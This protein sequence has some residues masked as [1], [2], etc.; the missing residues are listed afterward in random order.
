MDKKQI[1]IL[2]QKIDQAKIVSFDLYDTL[3][4]RKIRRPKDIFDLVEFETGIP[5]FSVSREKIQQK[6]ARYLR[7]KHGYPHPNLHEIY[8]FWS[9]SSTGVR[10]AEKIERR[11]EECLAVPN[12]AMLQILR[13]AKER[14]RR[15]LITSDMYLEGFEIKKILRM[16]AITDWDALYVSS[17]IRKTKYDGTIYDTVLEKEKVSAGEILHI[18][19]DRHADIDM[20]GQKGIC[21]FWYQDKERDLAQ[22][23]YHSSCPRGLLI[24]DKEMAFWYCLGYQVGG[25]LYMGLCQWIKENAAGQK[26]YCLSRDGYNLS[27][28]LPRFGI[29]NAVYIYASRRALLLPHITRIGP[30]E[31]ALL[32]PYSCGQTAGEI[33]SSIG[34]EGI[35][36]Q[37]LKEA[38]FDGYD[39]VIRNKRDIARCKRLYQKYGKQLLESCRK[40]RNSLDRYFASKGMFQKEVCFFDSGWN[41][42]SQYLIQKIYQSLHKKSRLQFYY[43]GIKKNADSKQKLKGCRCK[44]YFDQTM[45]KRTTNKLL[46][47]SAVLELFF[48]EDAPAVKCYGDSIQFEA[49]DKRE[50]IRCINQGIEDYISQNKA[51]CTVLSKEAAERFGTSNL[52]KLVLKP[53]A[54]EAEYIGNME[55]EDDLSKAGRMKKYMARISKEALKANPFLD[56]YWEQG[57]YRHPQNTVYVKAYVWF[58]QRTAGVYKIAKRLYQRKIIR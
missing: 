11:L 21:V 20:A 6:A 23:L 50:Y 13:Y 39:D 31:L 24:S 32:P 3:I 52:V 35:T 56:I 5:C 41:G 48:S 42:T 15:I 22:S 33:L 25:P 9:L 51:L 7:K 44:S 53:S 43:A 49:Y 8:T 46:A 54:R 58:R 4:F 30:K 1:Q 29:T 26:L 37:E 10:Q 55:C 2:K 34:L 45:D 18:G 40:E 27:R 19:D 38:G 36:R 28:L 14:G 17:E 16:C 12:L 47:S 57:V